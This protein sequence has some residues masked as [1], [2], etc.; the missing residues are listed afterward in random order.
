MLSKLTDRTLRLALL[1]ALLVPVSRAVSTPTLE[2]Q[3]S[4]FLRVEQAFNQGNE[5]AF[6][7]LRDSLHDYPLLPAL[8]YR[9]LRKRLADSKQIEDFLQ[10]YNYSYYSEQLRLDW[11]RYLFTQKRWQDFIAHYHVGDGV[12]FTCQFYWA[13]YQSDDK[14]V[15]LTEAKRLWLSGDELPKACQPL[16][17]AFMKSSL[18]SPALIWQR[19]EI[20]LQK[21]HLN[22]ANQTK[23]LLNE[24]QQSQASAWLAVR[25]NPLLVTA[26]T[27][28]SNAHNGRLFAYGIENLARTK[29]NDALNLWDLRKLGLTIDTATVQAL[30]RKLA[31]ALAKQRDDR[32]YA[33]L[34]DLA[35]KDTEIKE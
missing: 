33:R 13:H 23:N 6:M 9:R 3:R 31:L 25:N 15:A 4:D 12:A 29:L 1:L 19:F 17:A 7:R 5:Q 24:D 16:M 26:E 35:F 28:I 30:E 11:L 18:V 32:A 10:K 27:F 22:V 2:Q 34:D 20:A 14:A 8:D 21:D